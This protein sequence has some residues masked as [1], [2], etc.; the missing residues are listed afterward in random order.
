MKNQPAIAI[1]TEGTN[2]GKPK[3]PGSVVYDPE[4]ES[5]TLTGSG[6]KVTTN[7]FLCGVR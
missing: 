5:F 2:V 6:A 7:S 3:I 4:N 1:F